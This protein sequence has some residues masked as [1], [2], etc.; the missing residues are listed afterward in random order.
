MA[1]DVVKLDEAKTVQGQTISI[2]TKDGVKLNG[3]AKVIKADIPCTNGVIHV[4]D[5]VML[6]K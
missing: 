1:A 6:P 2:S 4:I 5:T 3:S